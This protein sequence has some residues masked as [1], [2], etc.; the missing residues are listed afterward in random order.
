MAKIIKVTDRADGSVSFYTDMIAYFEHF[1]SR[2]EYN[3]ALEK[4]QTPDE[5]RDYF[6]RLFGED[7]VNNTEEF[8]SFWKS[9]KD[10]IKVWWNTFKIEAGRARRSD[11]TLIFEWFDHYFES[12]ELEEN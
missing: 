6:I 11:G 9:Y 5:Q 8:D 10:A 12:I 4:N 7:R 1:Y 2:D 3:E